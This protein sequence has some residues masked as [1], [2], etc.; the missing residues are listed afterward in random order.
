LRG[1]KAEQGEFGSPLVATIGCNE[2]ADLAAIAAV[3]QK[4]K[5]GEPCRD[6]IC[7]QNYDWEK[8]CAMIEA[9]TF[10]P[11]HIFSGST[12][13]GG[14]LVSPALCI[15]AFHGVPDNGRGELRAKTIG[16]DAIAADGDF[17]LSH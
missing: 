17:N 16:S 12:G 8:P 10:L 5:T 14:S 4:V 3:Q 9:E 6:C 13:I 1:P 2:K 7:S 11:S 15:G